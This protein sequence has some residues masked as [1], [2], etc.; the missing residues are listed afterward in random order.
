ML[1]RKLLTNNTSITASEFYEP[2]YI[3]VF[4]KEAEIDWQFVQA[5]ISFPDGNNPYQQR[6]RPQSLVH[7]IEKH[8][9]I[10]IEMS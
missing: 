4:S 3:S 2:S 5:D 7:F 10:Q 8:L 1:N 6:I 9:N